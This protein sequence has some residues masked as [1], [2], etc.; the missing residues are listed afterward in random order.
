VCYKFDKEG[1]NSKE[2]SLKVMCLVCENDTHITHRCVWP[3]QTKPVMLAV[4]LADLE[5]GFFVAQQIR[6]DRKAGKE[7][8]LGL[9]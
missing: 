4:G 9:I 2:C 5:L 8:T 3:N 7:S 6:S 1:H